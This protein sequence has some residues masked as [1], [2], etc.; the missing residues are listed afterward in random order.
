MKINL[1]AATQCHEM[2]NGIN[3]ELNRLNSNSA[4]D[5]GIIQLTLIA[6]QEM[7]AV[8]DEYDQVRVS[9][10]L[11]NLQK[12]NNRNEKCFCFSLVVVFVCFCL[13]FPVGQ[14]HLDSRQSQRLSK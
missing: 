11:F 9:F 7:I 8:C 3:A 13:F 5:Q 6:V 1:D 14:Q 4:E 12:T 2:S 10:G